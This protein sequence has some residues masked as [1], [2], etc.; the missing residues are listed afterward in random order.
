MVGD[1]VGILGAVVFPFLQLTHD[2]GRGV[3]LPRCLQ[4]DGEY[5]P[6]LLREFLNTDSHHVGLNGD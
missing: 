6:E 2:V 4:L 3:E 5:P 1:H